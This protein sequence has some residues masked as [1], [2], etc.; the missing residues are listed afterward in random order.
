MKTVLTA[1][2]DGEDLSFD[3]AY[4]TMYGIMS[5]QFSDAQIGAFLSTLSAK[6]ETAQEIAGFATAMREKMVQVDIA[7]DAID[8]CGTGGDG[9]GTFNISTA[10]SF[11]VAGAGV[12]VAKHGNRSISSKSGSADVL[13]ELGVDITMPA[14]KIAHTIDEIGLG[15]LF[16]PVFHPAMKH[17]MPARKSL[18]I[19]TVFNILGPLCNPAKVKRQIIGIYDG[20]LTDKMASVL[21]LLDAESAMLM[22]AEDGMDEISTTAPTRISHLN[23]GGEINALTVGPE[24]VGWEAVQMD[25]LLGGNAKENAAIIQDIL[26]GQPG[27]KRD[28]VAINAAA[29]LIVGG[30]VDTFEEGV[31]LAEES[32]DSGSAKDVL[33]KLASA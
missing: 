5:G 25:A 29:G 4:E 17:V 21:K 8:M 12:P 24:S 22:H 18:G 28:I 16:A 9:I 27:P 30:K 23:N 20:E 6:G 26:D 7:S 19:R 10:A 2:I 32:I 3:E 33:T 13:A 15:F 14:G 11:V 31:K 1:L